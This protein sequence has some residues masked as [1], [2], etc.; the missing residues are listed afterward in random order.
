MI[1]VLHKFNKFFQK[2]D[3]K[4]SNTKGSSKLEKEDSSL[5][6]LL[7]YQ[8]KQNYNFSKKNAKAN[9]GSVKLSMLNPVYTTI[10]ISLIIILLSLKFYHAVP[11]SHDHVFFKVPVPCYY[12]LY[13]V[14]L[15]IFHI[16]NSI[17]GI[18][19]FLIMYILITTAKLKLEFIRDTSNTSQLKLIM[20]II[21]SLLYNVSAMIEAFI[22]LIGKDRF[23]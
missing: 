10:N 20:L 9:D 19:G 12:Q 8:E 7:D 11:L 6:S 21:F 4:N 16:Y 5:C 15:L 14:N 1:E 17:L 18:L 2:T 22:P 23:N 3:K 13:Q